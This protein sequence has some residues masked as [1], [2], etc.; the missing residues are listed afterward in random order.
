MRMLKNTSY[1]LLCTLLY[2]PEAELLQRAIIEN[3]YSY[4]DC[5]KLMKSF[6][7]STSEMIAPKIMKIQIQTV[8]Q[9]YI[10]GG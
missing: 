4:Y 9:T 2:A 7:K 1:Q 6:N 5:E 8:K 10:A 3:I